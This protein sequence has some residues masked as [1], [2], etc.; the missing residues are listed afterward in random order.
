MDAPTPL[1]LPVDQLPAAIRRFCDPAAPAAAR[2]MAARGLVPVKGDDQV[3]MLVQLAA[4]SEEQIAATAREAVGKLPDGV[5]LSA[6]DGEL[7]PSILD[8][9]ADHVANLG[10]KRDGLERI[11]QNHQTSDATIERIARIA[12]ER[13]CELIA[14]NEQRLLGAPEIIEAIYKNRNARMSTADRLVELAARNGV[15]LHGIPAFKDHVAAL[16]GKLIPAEPLEEPLPEDA[17]FAQAL[18]GDEDDPEAIEIDKVEGTE[19]VKE[20]FKPLSFQIREMSTSEKLRLTLIGNAA[21]RA[22]LVRDSNRIVSHAAIASP[23]MTESEAVGIAHSKEVSE[24]VL[25]FIGN[26]RREWLRNY[27]LKRALIFNP[28][29]PIGISLSFL[30]HLRDADLRGLARSRNVSAPIKTAAAQRLA[31]KEKKG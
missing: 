20:K 16:Q 4:S 8:G 31:K 29:T 28:K 26:N 2:M 18:D 22:L 1:P 9:L 11:V 24:D 10:I 13:L 25:R 19:E 30:S 5:L 15:E 27:E 3:T 23:T 14:T 21:A 7:H 12:D 6:C 17:A